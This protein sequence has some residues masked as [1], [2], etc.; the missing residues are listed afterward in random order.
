MPSLAPH[1]STVPDSGIRRIYEQALLLDDAIMLVVG[2]PDVPVARHIGD[3]ARR[4]WT[5]DRTNYTPNGGIAPLRRALQEKL[6]RENRIDAEIEQVW[7]TVG[8]TQALHQAMALLL[9]PG[10]EVLVP[11][12][13]YTTFTMN[14][15]MLGAVPVPYE[16]APA[17]GFEPDLDALEASVTDRTRVLLLNS[18]SN[19]LGSVVGAET[20]QRLLAFARRHDLWVISDEVYEYFTFGARHVSPASLDEDDRVFSVFSLSKT[21]AMTGVRVGYLVTPRGM[22]GTMRTVQEATVSCVAEPDQFAALAAIVGD[23]SAVQEARD[24]YRANLEVARQ[25]LDAKGITYNDPEGAFYLW[26]DVAHATD[27]DVAAW[28]ERFLLTERVA[29]APGSAFGRAGEGW[30]RVCLAADP[31]VLREG[32]RR[33]PDPR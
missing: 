25:V 8:A 22:A 27:G 4:A 29:V 6:S 7:V 15:H 21:Y 9:A 33:L 17:H 18:P 14:A 3:A 28:A 20:V 10:D 32:L 31:A 11:D 19:P 23:H 12:P 26:I 5:E 1:I 24:H 16:L 30:I 2:E 13:G